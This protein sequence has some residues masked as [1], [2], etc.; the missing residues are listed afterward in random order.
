MAKRRKLRGKRLLV[1]TVSLAGAGASFM[2]GCGDAAVANL[3][4]PP[5]HDATL[6]ATLDATPDATPDATSDATPDAMPDATP[7]ATPDAMPDPLPA[8]FCATYATMCPRGEI[9]VSWCESACE[10]DMRLDLEGCGFLACAV[11]VGLCDNEER[12]DAMI[13]A[14][15]VRHGWL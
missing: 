2:P 7:D 15:M 3:V 11:E 5:P 14:C 12:D 9:D 13:I 8:G 6:D 10:R 1:A 4:P